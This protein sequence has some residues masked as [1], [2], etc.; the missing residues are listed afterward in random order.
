MNSEIK[1]VL[2]TNNFIV[3]DEYQKQK[4]SS[5]TYQSEADL[6]KE[7]ISDLV[8]QGYEY[9][10]DI[11]SIDTMM[12]NL[13]V[14]LETL[15]KTTFTSSEWKRF[16]EE[17]LDKANDTIIDKTKK[18]MRIISTILLLTM[19]IFKIFIFWIKKTYPEILFK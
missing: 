13:K 3:L 2:E 18:F 1:P 17:Y 16:C 15:N 6:E 5:D 14:Q 9:R 11:S 19:D 12:D 10:K 7:L 8:S 4:A